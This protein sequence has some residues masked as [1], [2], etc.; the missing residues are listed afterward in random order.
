MRLKRFSSLITALATALCVN[1]SVLAEAEITADDIAP[2]GQGEIIRASNFTLPTNVISTVIE[3]EVNYCTTEDYDEQSATVELDSIFGRMT[4]IGLNTVYIRTTHEGKAFFSTDMNKTEQT[5]YIM[6]ATEMAYSYNIKPVLVLD[7]NYI[8]SLSENSA[9]IVDTLVSH[10]HRFTL[11]Y[12]CEGII[13]DNYYAMPSP[14]MYDRYMS[15]GG[16]I[17]Y[18]NWLYDTSELYF[19]TASEIIHLT[20]NSVPVGIMVN[21]MWANRSS[22]EQGSDTEDILEAYYDGYTDTKRFLEEGYVDFA[23]IHCYGSIESGILPFEN[24]A[25]WWSELCTTN[26]VTMYLMMCNDKMGTAEGDWWREDQLLRQLAL[27]SEMDSFGGCIFRSYDKL[28]NDSVTTGNLKKYFGNEI[29]VETLFEDLIMQSPK[30]LSFTTYEPYVDFM[31]TFDANFDVYFN[32][33]KIILN[34]AGNFYFEEPLSVGQNKFTIEH[35][36]TVYT[37][38]IERKVIPMKSLGSSISEG[39][40]LEVSGGT[41]ITLTAVAY[42]DSTVIASI[43]GQSI[44]LKQTDTASEDDSN[45]SYF[46]Y[47]GT[48]RVPAGIIG[49]EQELGAITVTADYMGYQTTIYGANVTVL[50]DPE[51]I[52]PDISSSLIDQNSVGTGEV[53]GTMDAVYTE[54]DIVKYVKISNDYTIVYDGETAGDIATPD[55]AQ[56][57]AGTLDYYYAASGSYYLTQS[58]KRIPQSAA[59]V[60][61]DTGLGENAL[62]VNSIG[63]YENYSYIKIKLDYKSSYNIDFIGNTYYAGDPSNYIIT[64]FG[65]THIGITFD[66]ITSVTKLPSFENNYVFSEGAWEVTEV[67]GI[68]KFRLLLKLRQK[69][70]YSGCSARYNAEGELELRFPIMSKSL[71]DLVVVIDPGHGYCKYENVFD[72]GAVGHVTEYDANLPIA[73]E[74]ESQL[75]ACGATVIRIKSESEFSFTNSRPSYGRPYNANMFIS[76]HANKIV[77]N[78]SVRGTEVYYFTPYSQPLAEQISYN[79]A[80]YFTNN[81]YSDGADKN[82]G[83]RY[84]YYWVTLQQD[85]PSVLIETG[86]VSNLED[87]MA[88]V[89]AEHQKGIAKAIVTGIQ[90]YVAR[91]SISLS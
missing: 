27:A 46:L 45:S 5:D 29:D 42:K 31:G 52:I 2:D 11:K 50:A 43:N 83:A 58:G 36:G 32:G 15:V 61:E 4:E 86:F 82:R 9:T 17:G 21:D 54:E 75:T 88:I 78:E 23:V 40:T 12:Q 34:E 8:V 48:Y 41:T 19:S 51:P 90:N 63:S 3:P 30:N 6:L 76:I 70:V 80:S 38:R 79:V 28:I 57:P 25:Q 18:E 67:D 26:G 10:I 56:L 49:L 65:A 89:N 72:P 33:E 59:T 13:I 22:N 37:Y 85:F 77:G 71:A 64:D 20:N 44:T 81:V 55:F 47:T 53:V 68:P 84:S 74:L 69:G 24:V 35:K 60:F 7:L 14:E 1:F 16:G 39:K 66:N 87:A 62:V 73:K 91:S